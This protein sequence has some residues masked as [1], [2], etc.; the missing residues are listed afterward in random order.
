MHSSGDKYLAVQIVAR[1]NDDGDPYLPI[2]WEFE[3]HLFNLAEVPISIWDESCQAGHAMLSFQLKFDDGK[4]SL[5]QRAAVAADVWSNFPSKSVVI[6]AKGSHVLRVGWTSEFQGHPAWTGVPDPDPRKQMEIQAVFQSAQSKEASKK[7]IWMGRAVSPFRRVLLANP[8]FT[9]PHDCFKHGFPRLALKLMS[10]DPAWIAKTDD[11]QCTPLHHAARFGTAESVTWLIEHK[12]DVNAAAY[13]GFTPL[14]LTS[15]REIAN[16]LIKAGANL[17][18]RDNW[19]KTALQSAVEFN[20]QGVVDAIIDSGYKMDLYTAI[21]L[22]K[23]DLA[24]KMLVEDPEIVV[25]GDGGSYIHGNTTPLGAAAGQGDLELVRLLLKAGAP[26]DDPTLSFRLGGHV[27]PL[28]NAVWAGKVEMV[29]FLL[30]QGAATNVTGGKFESS[31]TSYAEKHSDRRIVN[32]LRE[33]SNNRK[34]QWIDGVATVKNK[35]PGKIAS[36]EVK[37]PEYRKDK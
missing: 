35:L 30:K 26:I 2:D 9:S 10:D 36:G 3:V 22:K 37:A 18:Q 14:H 13:N 24:I 33:H 15:K 1:N 17:D 23:R 27:T 8:L 16:V 25:G 7:G 28:C 11:L 19:G 21:L 6:P 4:T 5:V 34:A 32:L 20:C 31:I 12:A 29:E